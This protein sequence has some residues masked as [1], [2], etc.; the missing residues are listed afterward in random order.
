MFDLRTKNTNCTECGV[1]GHG[2]VD[3]DV[4]INYVLDE[5]KMKTKP[6]MVKEIAQKY[7]SY[8]HLHHGICSP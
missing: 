2:L 1:P 5:L 8:R 7:T 4:K 3:C 6:S